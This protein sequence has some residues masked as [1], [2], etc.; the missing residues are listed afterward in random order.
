MVVHI[1]VV[2]HGIFM[3]LARYWILLDKFDLIYISEIRAVYIL[4]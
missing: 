2:K 3:F 1:S 4:R